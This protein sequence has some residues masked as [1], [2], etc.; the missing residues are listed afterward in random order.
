MAGKIVCSL[1][2]ILLTIASLLPAAPQTRRPPRAKSRPAKTAP[3]KAPRSAARTATPFTLLGAP[4]RPGESGTGRFPNGDASGLI[5]SA[6]HGA[7]PGPVIAFL[8]HGFDDETAFHE[9]AEAVFGTIPKNTMQGTILVLSLPSRR[10]CEHDKPCEP[11]GAWLPFEDEILKATRFV[12]DVHLSAQGAAAAPFV[13]VYLPP[14]NPRLAAY[15]KAMARACLIPN[16][17]QLHESELASVGLSAAALG[18]L[19]PRSLTLAHPAISIESATLTGE[20]GAAL[21]DGLR[22]LLDHLKMAAGAVSWQ[23]RVKEHSLESLA[24]DFFAPK[25]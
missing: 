5:A 4:V 21:R 17:V 23:N 9:A 2:L 20:A 16:E 8:F 10:I 1:A 7:R 11:E 6:F 19:A 18:H 15:V 13:F 12:V 24:P 22:N 25:S 14:D 3:R